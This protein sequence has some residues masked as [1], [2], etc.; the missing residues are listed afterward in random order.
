MTGTQ[1]KSM[2]RNNLFESITAGTLT[3]AIVVVG[4]TAGLLQAASPS[5]KIEAELNPAGGAL[6]ITD[7]NASAGKALQFAPKMSST[8][9]PASADVAEAGDTAR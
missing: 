8:T 5:A 6:V 7:T 9:S 2:I 4:V 3:I 1:I